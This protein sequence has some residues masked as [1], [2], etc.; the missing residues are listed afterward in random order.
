MNGI[1]F[2]GMIREMCDAFKRSHF[3][4]KLLIIPK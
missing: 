3:P 4:T 1:S 2:I